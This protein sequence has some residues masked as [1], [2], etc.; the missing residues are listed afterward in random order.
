M[1]PR[2]NGCPVAILPG[3][4]CLHLPIEWTSRHPILS[5]MG[6]GGVVDE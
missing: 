1:A 5:S 4:W 6:R 2:R 3:N